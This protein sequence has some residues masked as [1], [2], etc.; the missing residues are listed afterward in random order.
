MRVAG[1]Q[2]RLS[3]AAGGCRGRAVRRGR[4]TCARRVAA[5]AAVSDPEEDET[6][7]AAP[8]AQR[9]ELSHEADVVIVGA[10]VSGLCCAAVLASAGLSVTVC[11]AHT[12]AG[13]AAHHF[14]R[15]GHCFDAG[16]AARSKGPSLMTRLADHSPR[17][18]LH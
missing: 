17:V 9:G 13:G 5:R 1:T 15:A 14:S 3:A 7:D 11:E 16:A 8:P 18:A 4:V 12:V 6:D 2:V 10:G